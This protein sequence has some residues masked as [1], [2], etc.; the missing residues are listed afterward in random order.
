MKIIILALA[1]LFLTTSVDAQKFYTKSGKIS[2]YSSTSVE[3][4]EA[5]NRSVVAMVDTKSGDIQFVVLMKGFSFKKALMQEHFNKDY[6]ESHKFPKAEFKGT[7]TNNGGI[8]YSES[9]AYSVTVKGTLTIH[10]Q[11]QP[12]EASGKIVVSDTGLQLSSTFN[13]K[14]ADYNISVP[15]IYR[16]N[17]SSTIKVTVDCKLDALK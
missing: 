17:I 5:T 9:G 8:K 13:V 1:F 3:D 7:V 6:V 4:I 16:D 2:F 14:I 15:R 10:G 12:I 11:S